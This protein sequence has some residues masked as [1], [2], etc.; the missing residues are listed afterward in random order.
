MPIK[1]RRWDLEEAGE[2]LAQVEEPEA[3]LTL[4]QTVVATAEPTKLIKDKV[5]QPN[6]QS[7]TTVV[8]MEATL[9]R[10]VKTELTAL[11]IIFTTRRIWVSRET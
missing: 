8:A 2:E 9:H 7:Q 1:E 11:T 4:L 6:H 5:E 10:T 3:S